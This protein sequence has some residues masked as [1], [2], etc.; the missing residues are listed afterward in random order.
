MLDS[1]MWITFDF[2]DL[3]GYYASK[4]N[5]IRQDK[6]MKDKIIQVSEKTYRAKSRQLERH[7]QRLKKIKVALKPVNQ[8]LKNIK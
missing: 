1:E 2:R 3:T 7:G 6:Y 8:I 4:Y 5:G